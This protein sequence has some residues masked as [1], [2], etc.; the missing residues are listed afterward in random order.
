MIMIPF[1][2][3][4]LVEHSLDTNRRLWSLLDRKKAFRS[5]IRSHCRQEFL[6]V[7][8]LVSG[9]ARPTGHLSKSVDIRP[10]TKILT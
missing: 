5:G 4:L 2:G 9:R 6:E 3:R 1:A 8:L 7:G 10:S